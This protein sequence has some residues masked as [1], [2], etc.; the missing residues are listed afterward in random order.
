MKIGEGATSLGF[1][2]TERRDCGSE[3]PASIKEAS[4]AP[5]PDNARIV[6]ESKNSGPAEG[7]C[8]MGRAVA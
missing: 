8:D 6:P 7:T 3:A 2:H 4:T 5:K 1:R